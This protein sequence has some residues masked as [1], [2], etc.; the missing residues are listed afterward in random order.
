[1]S[2][3]DDALDTVVE[4]GYQDGE[5]RGFARVIY[6]SR[7]PTYLLEMAN[8]DTCYWPTN[9]CQPADPNQTADYWKNRALRAE[10]QLRRVQDR[11]A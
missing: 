11:D 6:I 9:S 10:Q 4:F 2:A 3:E 7:R 8:G 5:P 1:M